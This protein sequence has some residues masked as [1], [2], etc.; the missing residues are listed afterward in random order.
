MGKPAVTSKN[1]DSKGRITLGEAFANKTLI[2]EQ[3]GDR[4]VLRIARVIPEAETWLY[5]NPAALDSVRRGLREA[6]AG[7]LV[8]G[9]DLKRA[10]ELADEIGDD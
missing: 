5:E 9:L 7:E 10:A 2:V 3:D 1:T 4:I 6:R 8:D